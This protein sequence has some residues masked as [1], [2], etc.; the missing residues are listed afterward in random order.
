MIK[1]AKMSVLVKLMYY[2]LR[3]NPFNVSKV[4]WE[5]LTCTMRLL[6]FLIVRS[7]DL[8]F[9]QWQYWWP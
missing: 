5:T 1:I 9:I 8:V 2:I 7:W 6:G 4:G 3:Y